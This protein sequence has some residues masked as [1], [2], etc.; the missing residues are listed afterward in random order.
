MIERS[1]NAIDK[2]QLHS[3]RVGAHDHH[4]RAQPGA[5]R[6]KKLRSKPAG[7]ARVGVDV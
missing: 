4:A 6:I 3:R 5:T 7:H 1:A 2:P